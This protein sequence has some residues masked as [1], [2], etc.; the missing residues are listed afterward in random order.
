MNGF[1]F[2]PHLFRYLTPSDGFLSIPP[3]ADKKENY[4]NRS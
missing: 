3:L 2:T 1:S 4:P